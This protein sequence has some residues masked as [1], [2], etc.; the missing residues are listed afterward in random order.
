MLKT[1]ST[2][3]PGKTHSSARLDTSIG[4]L[5][6]ESAH[7]IREIASKV[8][9]G[10]W[11]GHLLLYILYPKTHC[12]PLPQIQLVPVKPRVLSCHTHSAPD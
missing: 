10:I 9:R 11:R 4:N 8:S 7:F 12:T 2:H 6:S 3:M 1:P 5:K